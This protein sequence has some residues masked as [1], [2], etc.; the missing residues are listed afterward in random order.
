MALFQPFREYILWKVLITYRSLHSWIQL[1]N[2]LKQA[3]KNNK[4][5]PIIFSSSSVQPERITIKVTYFSHNQVT[6]EA[7][8][9]RTTSN[10]KNLSVK[11]A[12][13]IIMDILGRGSILTF[14]SVPHNQRES[15]QKITFKRECITQIILH[16]TGISHLSHLRVC[17]YSF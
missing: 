9:L 4:H 3:Y 12:E 13:V 17:K 10:I 14:H 16:R 8:T 2:N 1:L 7:A 6:E 5:T 11:S 15:F